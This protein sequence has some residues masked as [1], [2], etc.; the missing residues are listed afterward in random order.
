MNSAVDPI[1]LHLVDGGEIPL[2]HTPGVYLRLRR[3]F[4]CTTFAEVEK[5]L[6]DDEIEG[7]LA[8]VR[9][10]MQR[11]EDRERFTDL[12]LLADSVDVLELNSIAAELQNG[13]SRGT[14]PLPKKRGRPTGSKSGP[15]SAS[16]SD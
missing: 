2:R 1:M 14:G 10:C 12:Y 3:D 16:T 11:E 6:V 13:G 15:S 8:F 5:R 4:G 9:A 7:T